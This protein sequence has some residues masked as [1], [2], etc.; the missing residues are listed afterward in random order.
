[1]WRW[2]R[3]SFQGKGINISIQWTMISKTQ[4]TQAKAFLEKILGSSFDL[5]IK[6]VRSW[7][8]DPELRSVARWLGKVMGVSIT[9]T[10]I[11]L[12][13][14]FLLVY[15]D[16]PLQYSLYMSW[17]VVMAIIGG[18]VMLVCARKE[19]HRLERINP[20]WRLRRQATQIG[21]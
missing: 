20:T 15:L 4:M 13:P 16:Q 14:L 21:D 6:P 3:A 12:G 19:T 5:T 1:M 17:F 10:A 9:A 11:F 2:Y 7:P 8:F 18:A